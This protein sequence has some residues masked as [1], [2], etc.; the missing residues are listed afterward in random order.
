MVIND[1]KERKRNSKFDNINNAKMQDIAQLI[2]KDNK[3]K[4]KIIK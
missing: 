3:I 4:L 2:F 1:K